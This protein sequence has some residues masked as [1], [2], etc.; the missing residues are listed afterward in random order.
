MILNFL[1]VRVRLEDRGGEGTIRSDIGHCKRVT[2][3]KQFNGTEI[4]ICGFPLEV[5]YPLLAAY[6][7]TYVF[8]EDSERQLRGW[9]AKFGRF[10]HTDAEGEYVEVAFA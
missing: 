9:E 3:G 7:N 10:W 2:A 8:R 1:S 5:F 6:I 4:V